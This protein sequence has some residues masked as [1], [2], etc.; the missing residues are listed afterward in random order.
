MHDGELH[1]RRVL[2]RGASDR[3]V[4]TPGEPRQERRRTGN[5]KPPKRNPLLG[6]PYEVRPQPVDAAAQAVRNP[7]GGACPVRIAEPPAALAGGLRATDIGKILAL[8]SSAMPRTPA[9]DGGACPELD[10]A[11]AAPVQPD[12]IEPRRCGCCESALAVQRH[13]AHRERCIRK[14]SSRCGKEERKCGE[15]ELHRRRG[16]GKV[17]SHAIRSQGSRA[18]PDRILTS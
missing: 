7:I 17:A 10:A 1:A 8:R 18:F 12:E 14:R 11:A 3:L 4:R 9:A 15:N 2:R 6:A 5:G 16:P 13:L